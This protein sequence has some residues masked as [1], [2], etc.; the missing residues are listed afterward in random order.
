MLDKKAALQEYAEKLPYYRQVEETAVAAVKRVI[1][2]QGFFVMEVA[3]RLKTPESLVGKADR[4][5]DTFQTLSDFYDLVGLRVITYFD[6]DIERIA[7]AILQEFEVCE[8]RDKRKYE[9]AR[10]FGYLSY[11]SICSLKD[12]GS[13]PRECYAIRFEL[14]I[15]TVL[16]HA[17]AEIEHD[18]GYKSDFGIPFALRRVFSR[19]AGLLEIADS[20]FSDARKRSLAY[21][22]MIRESI[23]EDRIAELEISAP[24]LNIYVAS[25]SFIR[26]LFRELEQ[27]HGIDIETADISRYLDQLQWLGVNTLGEFKELFLRGREYLDAALEEL[28]RSEQLDIYSSDAILS[29]VMEAELIRNRY[30]ENQL[31]QFYSLRYAD[32]ARAGKRAEKIA[33]IIESRPPDNGK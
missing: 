15:R 4:Y 3:H 2:E 23:R 8:I 24:A 20:Q 18:L 28:T 7:P 16:Q 30:A 6:E 1:G 14:Q 33:R 5:G 27:K 13:L 19:I 12:D 29:L 21:T 11:H 31:I 25:G 17:W 9:N 26:E 22:E 10:E 32:K